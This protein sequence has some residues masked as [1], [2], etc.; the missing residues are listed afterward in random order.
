MDVAWFVVAVEEKYL[1][2]LLAGCGREL[3]LGP[4]IAELS[5]RLCH[6]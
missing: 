4:I 2:R 3:G 5:L 6:R 1:L